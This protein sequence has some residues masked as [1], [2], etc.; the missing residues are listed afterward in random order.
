MRFEVYLYV[1]FLFDLAAVAA[2]EQET[3]NF[4]NIQ[5]M[6]KISNINTNNKNSINTD[7]KKIATRASKNCIRDVQKSE[8]LKL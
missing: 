3:V 1:H 5:T 4:V 2:N 6:S 8:R 7:R